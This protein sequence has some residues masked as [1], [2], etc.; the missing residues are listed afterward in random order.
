ML[1]GHTKKMFEEWYFFKYSPIELDNYDIDSNDFDKLPFSFQSGVYLE[2]LREQGK[3]VEVFSQ[4]SKPKLTYGYK[5]VQDGGNLLDDGFPDYNTAL[6][7]A[8]EKCN[9]LIN[10]EQK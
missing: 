7:K 2:F 10:G 4:S 5:I 3:I 9:E 6:T 8:I 1:T